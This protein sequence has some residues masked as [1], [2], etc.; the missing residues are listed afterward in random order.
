MP[1]G[2][3]LEEESTMFK[4]ARK[5]FSA[6]KNLKTFEQLRTEA[7]DKTIKLFENTVTTNIK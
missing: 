4:L 2:W 3:T 5:L 6:E 1:A 7:D